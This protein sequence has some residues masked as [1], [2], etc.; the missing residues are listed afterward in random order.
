[1]RALVGLLVSVGLLCGCASP[2]VEPAADRYE[3]DMARINAVEQAATRVGVRVY[4]L[5]APRKASKPVD[6]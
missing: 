5:N 6:G 1:M 4:W 3:V 2:A